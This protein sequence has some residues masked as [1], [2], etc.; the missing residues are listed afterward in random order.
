VVVCVISLAFHQKCG[1]TGYSAAKR[2]MDE[3]E[4]SIPVSTVQEE[5]LVSEELQTQ[6]L[7]P[8]RSLTGLAHEGLGN[9]RCQI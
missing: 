4:A 6:C 3:K 1:R 8:S 5:E 9:P 7:A 2:F